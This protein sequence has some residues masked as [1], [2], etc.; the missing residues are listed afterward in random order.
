[1][2]VTVRLDPETE[3][4]LDAACAKA[5]MT[6]SD[7]I[8][9]RLREA[10]V[11]YQVTPSPHDLGKHLF[12]RHDSGRADLSANRKQHLAELVRGKHDAR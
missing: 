7:F 1:M 3:R 8:R 2:T 5:G 6:R 4:S 10:L 11:A 12:G 9:E